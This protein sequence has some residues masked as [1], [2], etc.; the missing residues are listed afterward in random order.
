MLCF[1]EKRRSVW[2]DNNC[3]KGELIIMCEEMLFMETNGVRTKEHGKKLYVVNNFN[4][5]HAHTSMNKSL[6]ILLKYLFFIDPT[7]Y[8]F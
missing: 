3:V 1:L 4:V 8:L 7:S 2:E 5:V 6:D